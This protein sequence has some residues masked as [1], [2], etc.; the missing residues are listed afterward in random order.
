MTRITENEIEEFAIELLEK[1]VY[2]YYYG[3]D[4]APDGETPMRASFED[5]LLLE[6]VKA[7]IDRLNPSIPPATRAVALKQIQRF[8]S[9]ELITNNESFHRMLT[10][11]INVTYRKD[12]HPRGDY[13]RLI[14]FDN[15]DKNEFTVVNQFTVIENDWW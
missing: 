6:K 3:P 10:E 1:S 13:V 4:I 2:Q 8:H 7:A 5:V 15:P 12:G 9:P 14:D 11:G